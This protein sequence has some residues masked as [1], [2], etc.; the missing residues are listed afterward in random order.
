MFWKNDGKG[1]EEEAMNAFRFSTVGKLQRHW[2]DRIEKV[3]KR[4]N[5]GCEENSTEK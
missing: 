2:T 4:A 1:V 5:G 3:K